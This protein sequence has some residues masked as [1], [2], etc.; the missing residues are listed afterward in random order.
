MDEALCRSASSKG[1]ALTSEVHQWVKRSLFVLALIMGVYVGAG[2]WAVGGDL[3]SASRQLPL[4]VIPGMLCLVFCGLGLRSLRWWYYVRYLKWEVPAGDTFLVFFASFAF[5]ATPNKA[6][7]VIKSVLLR[8]RYAIP[9]TDSIAVLMVERLGD[10]LAVLVLAAG[11][12]SLMADGWGYFLIAALPL[13]GAI[14]LVS[15]RKIYYPILSKIS[16]IRRLSG[17]IEKLLHLLDTG[18]ALLRPAPFLVGFGIALIAWACEGWAF[19]FLI[20]AFGV[21]TG[22]IVSCSIFGIATLAG[23]LSALP[24]GVG[25]FEVVMVLLLSRVGLS[26][27]A[28]TLPVVLFRCC[29]LW[30]TSVLGL[31]LLLAWLAFPPRKK[32]SDKDQR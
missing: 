22:P 30:L 3:V 2:L 23:A 15:N 28:A 20:K 18:R 12:L 5:T 11:G 9:L 24:G 29:T 4:R 16:G 10:L 21:S 6:G 26:M 1:T 8:T 13:G 17:I 25:S 32:I 19:D 14:V 7:E 31:L 27:S